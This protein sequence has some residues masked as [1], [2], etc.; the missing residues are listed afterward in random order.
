M[1]QAVAGLVLCGLALLSFHRSIPS[2]R[3]DVA[4]WSRAVRV[5]PSSPRAW[6]NLGVA[7]NEDFQTTKAATAWNHALALSVGR[8]DEARIR[9]VIL[10][11]WALSL[12]VKG[13]TLAAVQ[14]MRTVMRESR[15]YQPIED[16]APEIVT[17]CRRTKACADT[18]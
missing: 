17:L 16:V 11:N 4:L 13:H 2:F 7:R 12:A 15:H 1:R 18:L 3:S 5:S 9:P 10:T 14:T 8:W 6:V